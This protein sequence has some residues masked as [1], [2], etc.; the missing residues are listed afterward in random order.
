MVLI[1]DQALENGEIFWTFV[2]PAILPSIRLSFHP[3]PFRAILPSSS[4]WADWLGLQTLLAGPQVWL[5]GPQ[6]WLAG[7]QA[8]LAG[9]QD[10][11]TGPQAMLDS[12][13]G[14]GTNKQMNKGTSS[15]PTR[16]H[17]LSGLLPKKEHSAL[18]HFISTT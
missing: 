13:E 3:S 1:L 5:A 9:P 14:G 15:H 2:H 7:C 8:L 18:V 16:L 10:W 17:P 12:L 4:L 6:V 11:L